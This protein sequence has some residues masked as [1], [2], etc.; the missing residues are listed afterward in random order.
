MTGAGKGAKGLLHLGDL[1]TQYVLAMVEDALDGVAD[2]VPQRFILGL[3]VD[4]GHHFARHW[5]SF[6]LR[7]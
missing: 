4:E 1:G 2:L 3:Q 6:S 7:M 5:T